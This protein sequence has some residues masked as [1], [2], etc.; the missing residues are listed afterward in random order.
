MLVAI[1]EGSDSNGDGVFSRASGVQV[2]K[3]CKCASGVRAKFYQCP[4]GTHQMGLWT[5]HCLRKSKDESWRLSNDE[6]LLKNDG[7]YAIQKGQRLDFH[8]RGV[9]SLDMISPE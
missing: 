1:V 5:I 3:W 9:V 7:D 4:S 2:C 8:L 6:C